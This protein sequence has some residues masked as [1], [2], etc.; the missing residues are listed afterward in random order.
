[1]E[2][3]AY[4]PEA[5]K[6][7]PRSGSADASS[8]VLGPLSKNHVACADLLMAVAQPLG[9]QSSSACRSILIVGLRFG[10]CW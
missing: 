9:V 7:A 5:V 6:T 4:D 10:R 2:L 8:L 1:M 3:E